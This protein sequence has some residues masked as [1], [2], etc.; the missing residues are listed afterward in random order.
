MHDGILGVSA[1]CPITS[2]FIMVPSP[3]LQNN[4]T[5]LFDFSDC[6][7]RQIKAN[8]LIGS[9]NTFTTIK[10]SASCLANVPTTF[11]NETEFTQ[12]ADAGQIWSPDD[13]CKMIYG[14]NAS[15]C[16]V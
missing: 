7:V 6:S 13:Q 5:N 14:Q 11:P 8:V 15:F 12:Y 1:D 4:Q 9:L 16:R 10:Q 2:N 3:S